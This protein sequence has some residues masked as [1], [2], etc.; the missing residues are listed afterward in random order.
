MGEG[1]GLGGGRGRRPERAGE[2]ENPGSEVEEAGPAGLQGAPIV[3]A[4]A[5]KLSDAFF[6]V[7]GIC[8]SSAPAC[9]PRESTK[10]A[11]CSPGRF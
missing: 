3:R 9:G 8:D 6:P 5:P 11:P 7:E 1:P 10:L 4:P 2:Q